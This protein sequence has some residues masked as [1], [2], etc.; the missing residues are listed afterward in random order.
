MAADSR[1]SVS[2]VIPAFNEEVR[3]PSTLGDVIAYL[4]TTAW[5]W[6][7]RIVDDGSTD[8]TVDAAGRFHRDE[9]RVVI[10]PEPHRGKGAAVKA[11][12]L[13]ARGSY[14][15]ICDA[16]LSMPIAEIAR[17]LPPRLDGVDVAIATREGSGARRVGEP[18]RRHLVGRVFNN[19][20]Q[21]LLLPGIN[22]TQC[23][24]KMFTARAVQLI[25]PRV[26]I[27][28]WS[29]DIEALYVA[30]EQGLRLAEVPIE[31]HYRQESQVRMF[32]DSVA[33]LTE[34]L[35]IRRRAKSGAY[36]GSSS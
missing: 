26:T 35:R 17:F 18:L 36:R 20:V 11:G 24:F 9:P 1:L 28:G 8:G 21:L 14:R 3:L 19:L 10:Q 25:F 2:I 7:V 22:D 30:R 13:A 12:L 29:F 15:F 16:D 6:E 4:R 23:G 32:R 27:D 5:D 33:M 31:W 34:L